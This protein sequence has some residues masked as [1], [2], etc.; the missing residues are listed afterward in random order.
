MQVGLSDDDCSFRAKPF[1]EPG[2]VRRVAV[3]FAVEAHSATGGCAGQIETV[4]HRDGQSPKR[5]VPI[6]KWAAV[7]AG[8]GFSTRRFS[9][10]PFCVLP[11][12]GIP[13]GISVGTRK[14][15]VHQCGGPRNTC[16]K[17]RAEA[18]DGPRGSD[19]RK[20]VGAGSCY[21]GREM[22]VKRVS[23]RSC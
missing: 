4:F 18:A 9:A 3:E 22:L 8:H 5:T 11:Q 14:G 6:A 21:G 7:V 1:H 2:I 12:V 19:H 13:A 20:I 10:G 17:R 23:L 16:G 15:P